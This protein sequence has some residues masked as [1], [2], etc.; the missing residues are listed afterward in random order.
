MRWCQQKIVSLSTATEQAYVQFIYTLIRLPEQHLHSQLSM[1][2]RAAA[3]IHTKVWWIQKWRMRSRLSVTQIYNEV[4]SCHNNLA[5]IKGLVTV[6]CKIFKSSLCRWHTAWGFFCFFHFHNPWHV[7]SNC[8]LENIISSSDLSR[9][10][11]SLQCAEMAG[12]LH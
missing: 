4:P 5:T 12:L 7:S 2:V 9:Y 3:M 6:E 11:D 8:P 1:T 10:C